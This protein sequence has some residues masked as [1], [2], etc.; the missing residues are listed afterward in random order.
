MS[1]KRRR[2][3][4]GGNDSDNDNNDGDVK[5]H[6]DES[7]FH[8]NKKRLDKTLEKKFPLPLLDI[9][10]S[11]D[12]PCSRV[13]DIEKRCNVKMYNYMDRETRQE[14]NCKTHCLDNYSTIWDKLPNSIEVGHPR[15]CIDHL[16]AI[17]FDGI[18]K[19]GRQVEN[20]RP[21][22]VNLLEG[23]DFKRFT[24]KYDLSNARNCRER[25]SEDLNKMLDREL[26]AGRKIN[27]A[28]KYILLRTNEIIGSEYDDEW[29]SIKNSFN[30]GWGSLNNVLIYRE[31]PRT[32]V[33]ELR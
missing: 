20:M 31:N 24:I 2:E 9:I 29:Q 27:T 12:E 18:T 26:P 22:I 5:M 6:D 17:F 8:V 25:G 28:G 13:P 32:L 21:E 23:N 7:I 10:T 11:Y 14:I 1:R 30:P 16:K 19:D 4:D 3:D 33:V 15:I